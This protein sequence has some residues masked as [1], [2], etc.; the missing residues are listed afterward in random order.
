[1]LF[2]VCF[3]EG[4]RAQARFTAYVKSVHGLCSWLH[5]GGL[6]GVEREVYFA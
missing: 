5:L 6:Q 1:M 3:G 4:Q 2:G